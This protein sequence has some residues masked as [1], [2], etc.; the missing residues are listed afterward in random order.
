MP[1]KPLTKLL[2]GAAIALAAA[3][4]TASATPTT[5]SIGISGLGSYSV[6]TGNIT[7]ATAT[8]SIP[9]DELVTETSTPTSTAEAGITP[10]TTFATFSSTTLN[11]TV[12]ADAFTVSVGD[13]IISFT[14][15]SSAIK[16]ASG[17]HTN[18]S[19]SE[20]F[21][22][23]VTGDTSVGTLFLG[24]TAS[25][26]ETCTQTTSLAS[27]TC[28]DSLITPG[29]PITP[30]SVPEPVS[31]ALLGVGVFGLGMVRRRRHS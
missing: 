18:G 5:L 30:P 12:G 26:S 22:G 23:T 2:A 27:I 20:Q 13:L 11:T 25:I 6:N 10:L 17:L 29:L 3:T 19:I 4:G 16:V 9:A 21:N 8:K 7:L 31:L 24:Q 28:S 14:D 1:M 15:I